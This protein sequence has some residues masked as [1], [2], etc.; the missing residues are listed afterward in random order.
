MDREKCIK[1]IQSW[2]KEE[3]G[4][5]LIDADQELNIDSATIVKL[6]NFVEYDLDIN[7]DMDKLNFKSFKTINSFLDSIA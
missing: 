6:I 7:I 4:R 2:Y 3:T 5:E 1:E